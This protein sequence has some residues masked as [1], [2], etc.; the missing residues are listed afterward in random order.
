MDSL[1]SLLAEAPGWLSHNW[2]L[3]GLVLLAGLA[4][5]YWSKEA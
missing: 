4:M 1:V 5:G 3:L 2:A